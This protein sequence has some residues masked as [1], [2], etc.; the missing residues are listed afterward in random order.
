MESLTERALRQKREQA[1]W[2][3]FDV[4]GTLTTDGDVPWSPPRLDII[5]KVK[6]EIAA[7]SK[8]VLWSAT[9]QEYCR[10]FAKRY[11]IDGLEACLSKPS[12]YVDDNPQIRSP[13]F[14]RHVLPEEVVRGQLA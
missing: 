11:D 9:G 6:E 3:Y 7:G 12:V 14:M 4:D 13:R 8:V 2:V 5:S 1:K 10:E